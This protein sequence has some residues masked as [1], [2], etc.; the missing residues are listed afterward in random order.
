HLARAI[1]HPRRASETR[2][3]GRIK[4]RPTHDVLGLRA[5]KLREVRRHA[6]CNRTRPRRPG[7]RTRG[8]PTGGADAWDQDRHGVSG[9]GPPQMQENPSRGRHDRRETAPRNRPFHYELTGEWI[10]R[11]IWALPR[12]LAPRAS[13]AARLPPVPSRALPTRQP[14]DA[15]APLQQ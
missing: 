14:P 5:R 6:C 10:V 15:W 1:S 4:P 12:A 2:P 3:V 8:R 9:G 11:S 7:A 13:A